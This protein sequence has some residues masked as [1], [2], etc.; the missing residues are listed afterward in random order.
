[1]PELRFSLVFFLLGGVADLA[2]CLAE[3]PPRKTMQGVP[4]TCDALAEA[5][6]F[7]Q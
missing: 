6:T 2:G 1:M 5:V 4:V 7:E 3:V